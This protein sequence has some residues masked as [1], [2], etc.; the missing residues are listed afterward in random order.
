[1]FVDGVCFFVLTEQNNAPNPRQSS[2]LKVKNNI[3]SEAILLLTT[4]APEWRCKRC[5][6]ELSVLVLQKIDK[7]KRP[8]PEIE[9]GTSCNLDKP[10]AGIIPLDH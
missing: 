4:R 1:M 9:S 8:Q 3:L 6:A 2:S 5:T 7:R 10:K